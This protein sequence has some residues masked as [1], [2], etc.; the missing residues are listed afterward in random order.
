MGPVG[1]G[2]GLNKGVSRPDST[3]GQS[4]NDDR[5]VLSARTTAKQ[6]NCFFGTHPKKTRPL[7]KKKLWDNG[8]K[9]LGK[10]SRGGG[11]LD[12]DLCVST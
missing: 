9:M 12:C 5:M 8:Q 4:L 1:G 10:H 11:F 7:P 3:S 2:G 6:Q